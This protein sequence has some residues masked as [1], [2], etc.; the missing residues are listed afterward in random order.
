MRYPIFLDLTGVPVIVIGAGRVAT[1][2]IRSLLAAGAVVTVISPVATVSIAARAS[3]GSGLPPATRFRAPAGR[4]QKGAPTK[5]KRVPRLRWRR[6]RYRPG[7]LRG[8]AL[9]VAA[10]NDRAVNEAVC[11]EARRRK[12]L[13]NCVAP[14]EAGNFIVPA[15]LRRGKITLAIST[16]GANPG[17]AKALRQ[18]L[19]RRWPRDYAP[20]AARPRRGGAR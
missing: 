5:P 18:A 8:A 9:V 7:D 11:R 10:T 3:R 6:R 4:A 2:K 16:G 13:V 20:L 12:L 19:A 1:R 14:P 17:T 15:T